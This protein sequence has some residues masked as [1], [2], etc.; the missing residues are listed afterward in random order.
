MADV[1]YVDVWQRVDADVRAHACALWRETDAVPEQE[2]DK[3]AESLCVVAYEGADLVGVSTVFL[4]TMDA[5]RSRVGFLRVLVA[6][7]RRGEHLATELAGRCVEVLKAW[8]L[9][10]PDEMLKGMAAVI[11]SPELSEKCRDPVWPRTGLTV[12]GYTPRGEQI[13]LVWFDH[14]RL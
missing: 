9:D 12:I 13:R 1:R 2:R 8:S 3:R 7:G 11:Q 4:A 6:K 10:H 14:A 5:V